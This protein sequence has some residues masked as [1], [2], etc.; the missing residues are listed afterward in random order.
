MRKWRSRLFLSLALTAF[1]WGCSSSSALFSD[2]DRKS[3]YTVSFEDSGVKLVSGSKIVPGDVV[4]VSLSRMSGASSP[5]ALTIDL[6]ASN[7][8]S[9]ASLAYATSKA[10]R[11]VATDVKV[12]SLSGALPQFAL[13][14]NLAPGAYTLLVVLLDQAGSELQRTQTVVFYGRGGFGLDSLSLYPATALP[15]QSVLL[16]VSV[17]PGADSAGD[18]PW[19]R[20]TSDGRTFASGPLSKG[21]DKV[22]WRSPA[23]AGAYSIHVDLYPAEPSAAALAVSSP[24]NREIKA[25]VSGSS[26]AQADE[27]KDNTRLPV[28]LAFEGDFLDSGSRAQSV[29]P[30]VYGSSTLDVYPGGFGNRLNA[31]SS[32]TVPGAAPPAKDGSTAPFSLMWRFYSETNA[33]DLV[34]L[35]D[36]AGGTLLR[37]G[38]EDGRPFV[39]SGSAGSKMK[40]TATVRLASGGVSDLALSFVPKDGVYALV[41][42][43]NGER[44]ESSSVTLPSFAADTQAV[45][46]GAA[47]LPGVY[48]EFAISDD[49]SGAPPLYHAAALRRYTT[50]L[51][52]ADGFESGKLPSGMIASGDVSYSPRSLAL[53]SSGRLALK[54]DLSLSRPIAVALAYAPNGGPLAVQLASG[55]STLLSI[56]S[57]GEISAAGSAIGLLRPVGNGSLSFTVIAGADGIEVRASNG[58]PCAK[59]P[60]RSLPES[61]RLSVENPGSEP[62][63]LLSLLVRAAPEALSAADAPRMA[64]L[65]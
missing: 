47:A 2:A 60:M 18:A 14:F 25:V 63:R 6:L 7:G 37:V 11:S 43:V 34:R 41:W 8:T 32:V 21:L 46:G 4:S 39:E 23:A 35:V 55:E 59:L 45:L 51:L 61:L 1:T 9:V 28:H 57:T 42:S 29:K 44:T 54:D 52:S 16:S 64:R 19:L 49:A 22:V 62:A 24:W 48:D 53:G 13:P 5:E 20:W 33:G 50:D 3:I 17:N 12:T 10:N 31:S 40:S 27:F 38:L 15:D 65:K 36:A 58:L 30:S 26:D 56:T